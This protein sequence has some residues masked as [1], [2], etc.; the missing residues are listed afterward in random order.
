MGEI[1]GAIGRDRNF[2]KIG[3]NYCYLEDI[4]RPLCPHNELEDPFGHLSISV[5]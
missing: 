5:R 3:T 2:H 1:R 4:G